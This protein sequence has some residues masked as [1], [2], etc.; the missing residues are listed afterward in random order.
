[1]H[2]QKWTCGYYLSTISEFDDQRC[3]AILN[4]NILGTLYSHGAIVETLVVVPSEQKWGDL[5]TTIK[6]F[7][8]AKKLMFNL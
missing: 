2:H 5:E 4:V 3:L 8:N 1:M 7:N 6:I